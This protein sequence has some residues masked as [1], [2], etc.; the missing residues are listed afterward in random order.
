[1]SQ[2]PKP[3][4][5]GDDFAIPIPDD[6]YEIGLETCKNNLHARIIWPKGATPLTVHALREKLKPIWKSLGRWGVTSP[7]KGYYEFCFS[8]VEDARSVRSIASWN[9]NPGLLKLFPW[10]KE[11]N[12]NTQKNSSAQV[13]MRIYGLGQEYWRP[14]ILFAIASSVGTPICTDS[15]T[16]KPML[17]RTFGHFA[18]VLV[19]IDLTTELKYKV[20]V[21]RKGFAMFVELDY[22]KI[23]EYCNI[24][25]MV[26]HND[27]K[28]RRNTRN[29]IEEHAIKLPKDGNKGKEKFIFKEKAP[30]MPVVEIVAAPNVEIAQGL[31]ADYQDAVNIS[32]D[33]NQAFSQNRAQ[34]HEQNFVKNVNEDLEDSSSEFVDATQVQDEDDRS[35][36][37]SSTHKES[38]PTRIQNDMHF[39][40]ESWANLADH[41]PDDDVVA[42]QDSR[43]INE[44]VNEAERRFQNEK[45]INESILAEEQ[46]NIKDSGFQLVTNRKKTQKAKASQVKSNYTTRSKPSNPKPFK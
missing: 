37:N 17:E 2:L 9:L 45:I 19:D 44:D 42:A 15:N 38:T 7:G 13:W 25:R 4:R 21:E 26:G 31:P 6:E 11:F 8:S 28:C 32:S 16:G 39:L 33:E 34:Q 36:T 18:R 40:H 23:P 24:C 20:W 5:K 10:T 3:S 27:G 43:A 46:R 30:E 1:M 29:D 14:K 41:K 22:E 12:S 35:S